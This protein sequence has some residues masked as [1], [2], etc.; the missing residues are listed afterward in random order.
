MKTF[1]SST[2]IES[3]KKLQKPE[4]KMVEASLEKFRFSRFRPSL[5]EEVIS[6]GFKSARVNLDLRIIFYEHEGTL[7]MAY[8]DHHDDAYDWA[9]NNKVSKSFAGYLYFENTKINVDELE[10]IKSKLSLFQILEVSLENI[11]KIVNNPS[12]AEIIYRIESLDKLYDTLDFL[13]LPEE[14]KT[15]ITSLANGKPLDEILNEISNN[16]QMSTSRFKEVDDLNDVYSLFGDD[17]ENWQIFLHPSQQQL[18]ELDADGPV[19]IEGGPGTGKTVVGIHRAL[20]LANNVYKEDDNK[21]LLIT[22][23]KKL[24]LITQKRL[25]ALAQIRN[26]KSNSITVDFLGSVIR[27]ILD[28]HGIDYSGYDDNIFNSEL[29]YRIDNF[30]G[31]KVISFAA[32]VKEYEQIV[33]PNRIKTL[34]DYLKVSRVGMAEEYDSEKRAKI[35][36]LMQY[37][38]ANKNRKKILNHED[39]AILLDDA[40]RKGIVKPMFHSIIVDEAQDLSPIKLKLLRKLLI[41]SN[42]NLMLLSD[43]EQRVYKINNYKSAADIE[44]D[45]RTYFLTL[46]YRTSKAIYNYAAKELEKTNREKYAR[47]HNS[48]YWGLAPIYR[49]YNSEEEQ[50]NKILEVVKELIDIENYKEYEI[51][52]VANTKKK[53]EKADA[54]LKSREFKTTLLTEKTF[55]TKESGV[56]LS[57]SV[58]VKGLEFRAIIYLDY[59]QDMT[60]ALPVEGLNQRVRYVACTRARE[61]LIVLNYIS[62]NN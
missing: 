53:L 2:F 11:N 29:K 58:G 56:C 20:H 4:I 14:T 33:Q 41:T 27:D 1:I 37:F 30:S 62:S 36:A 22:F 57:T 51:C 40:I 23:S 18:V 26:L 55:P 34:D 59:N 21:V 61:K 46:N 8:V 60:S 54:L 50:I 32:Y 45:N 12:F 19:L 24:A 35:W 31:E 28:N 9:N 39:V 52:I 7:I 43:R 6:N 44:V 10:I 25:M 42:N 38:I 48:L 47:E 3:V 13:K 5:N 15:G 16:N 17:F 49:D